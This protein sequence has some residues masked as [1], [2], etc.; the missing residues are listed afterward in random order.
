MTVTSPPRHRTTPSLR[1]RAGGC[2]PARPPAHPDTTQAVG[3]EPSIPEDVVI[4][5]ELVS[6]LSYGSF[7]PSAMISTWWSAGTP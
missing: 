5:M 1:R 4:A 3:V 6:V 2:P 7:R